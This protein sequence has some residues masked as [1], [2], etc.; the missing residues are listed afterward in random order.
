MTL[1]YK[2]ADVKSVSILYQKYMYKLGV[3]AYICTRLHYKS[4]EE[5]CQQKAE[6]LSNNE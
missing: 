4:S 6:G 2:A 3:E 1:A 5:H